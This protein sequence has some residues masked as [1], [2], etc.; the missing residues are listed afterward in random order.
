MT[1]SSR[2][3]LEDVVRRSEHVERLSYFEGK[4]NIVGAEMRQVDGQWHVEFHQ[5]SDEQRDS[6][7]F[8]ARL[9][10]QNKDD[11]SFQRLVELYD[12]P[13]IS[14]GWKREHCAIRDELN[15]RLQEVAADGVKGILTHRNVLNMFLYGELGHRDEDDREYR[16]FQKWVTDD[17]EREL[18]HNTFHTVLIWLA[19]AIINVG[20]ISKREL[21]GVKAG[22]G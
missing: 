2:K 8:N 21:Q 10:V 9:F 13:G 12:D 6:L 4:E 19:V 1:P 7:L 18:L 20:R 17:T 22:T 15:R 16:L 3:R 14:D 11:I 5:P